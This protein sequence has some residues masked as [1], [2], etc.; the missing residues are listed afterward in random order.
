MFTVLADG[1]DDGNFE[2]I[3]DK[4][5]DEYVTLEWGFVGELRF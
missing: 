3:W 2:G 4:R 1:N 5:L